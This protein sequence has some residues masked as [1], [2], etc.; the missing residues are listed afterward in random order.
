VVIRPAVLE[1]VE[2]ITSIKNALLDST[3]I[4]WTDTPHTTAEISRWLHDQVRDR[5]PVLVAEVDGEVAGWAT[6]GEFRDNE[7]WPGY[8]FTV[9]HT[10]HVGQAYWG[11]GVGRA[12]V[13]ELADL[14]R[15]AGMHT[16]I[17]AVDG[18]N[19]A[20]IRFHERL[21]FVEVA[22][23]PEIGA[24]HGRWLDLVLLALQLDAAEQPPPEPD[25]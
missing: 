11:G 21:G 15:A 23:M 12:L 5:N 13:S 22:R 25:D 16:M 18:E 4:E 3:A 9:E 7:R 14:A 10:I 17:A 19:D 20:S 8:R 2:A 6:Y 1:D 24:K